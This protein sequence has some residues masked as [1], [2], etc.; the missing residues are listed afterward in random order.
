[1][2]SRRLTPNSSPLKVRFNPDELNLR[3]LVR[4]VMKASPS[5]VGVDASLTLLI[6]IAKNLVCDVAAQLVMVIPL[7]FAGSITTPRYSTILQTNLRG[8][9]C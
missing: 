8:L 9:G 5:R 7:A 2:Q 3:S 1:M 4:F 6:G